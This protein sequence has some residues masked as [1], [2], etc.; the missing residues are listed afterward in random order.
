[1][2][3][4]QRTLYLFILGTLLILLLLVAYLVIH[5]KNLSNKRRESELNQ[6]LL[7][8]QMN[9]HFIFNALGTIQNFIYENKPD[10][11][12]RYLAKFAKLMRNILES[13]VHERIPVDQEV[14]TITHYLTLQQIRSKNHFQF[15]VRTEGSDQE[16]RIPPMLAQ[17][18][19]ENSVK[20][21]FLPEQDNA[22]VSVLYRFQEENISIEIE[23]NGRG[24]LAAGNKKDPGHTSY[25]IQLT[26]ERLVLLNKGKRKTNHVSITDL[27]EQGGRGTKVIIS[28]KNS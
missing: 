13:S 10:D 23:D 18:F 8:S 11:A 5:Q 22:R 7:R 21:A 6:K 17:P 4:R 9:P 3:T 2:K 16:D 27:S 14:E 24:I 15:D 12:A 19:I 28:F 20:H 25:A 26:R 1:L